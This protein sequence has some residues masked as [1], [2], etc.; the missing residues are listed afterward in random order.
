MKDLFMKMEG[1]GG[2][3][4][5][6]G[7]DSEGMVTISQKAFDRRIEDRLAQQKRS[8][9]TDFEEKET[10]FKGDIK[11]LTDDFEVLKNKKPDDKGGADDSNLKVEL[12]KSETALKELTDKY[13]VVE[14][15]RDESDAKIKSMKDANTLSKIQTQ[16][17]S[18]LS[19]LNVFDPGDVFTNLYASKLIA[20]NENGRVIPIDPTT[21]KQSY[22][23][24]G[25]DL[26]LDGYLTNYLAEKPYLVKSSG[27][28]GSNS[29]SNRGSTSKEDGN[30]DKPKDLREVMSS[31]KFKEGE[32]KMGNAATHGGRSYEDLP[33]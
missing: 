2:G 14:K 6:D 26:D 20:L 29:R 3:A 11:K 5:G 16:V 9:M 30:T 17:V 24:E 22:D 31:K 12:H 21:Q 27:N 13:D 25:K 28:N 8:L 19:K 15:A 10:A 32:A 1:D 18:A 7:G 23:K 4:G 33:G